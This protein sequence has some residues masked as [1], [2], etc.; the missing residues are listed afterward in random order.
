M[1]VAANSVVNID[2]RLTSPEGELIDSSEGEAPLAY[3]HGHGQIVPGLERALLGKTAGDHLEVELAPADGYGERE[4]EKVIEISKEALPEGVSPEVGME[5]LADGPD[6]ELLPVWVTNVAADTVTLDANH[7]LAG[8][9]LCFAVTVRG[10]REATAE[11]LEHGH[12]HG[13]GDAH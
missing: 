10:V 5:L 11:E 12:V 8:Q 7:P 2:Y 6:G 13:E 9:T 4:A 3:L 1:K